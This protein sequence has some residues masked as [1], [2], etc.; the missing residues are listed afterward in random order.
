[1]VFDSSSLH[2]AGTHLDLAFL[3]VWFTLVVDG[4]DGGRCGEGQRAA[5]SQR[6]ISPGWLELR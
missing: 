3:R 2:C 4:F 1:M 6:A 5:V